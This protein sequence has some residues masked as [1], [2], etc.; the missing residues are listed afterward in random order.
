MPASSVPRPMKN[1]GLNPNQLTAGSVKAG[2]V[3]SLIDQAKMN[4][5]ISPPASGSRPT[6]KKFL[7][8]LKM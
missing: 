2:S 3:M 4:A 6:R 8:L 7:T 5:R 1:T